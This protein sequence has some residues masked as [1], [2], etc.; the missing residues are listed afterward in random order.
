[1]IQGN[2]SA[3]EITIKRLVGRQRVF[4][5]SF[6]RERSREKATAAVDERLEVLQNSKMT[7]A[8]KSSSKEERE[9][10]AKQRKMRK[11]IKNK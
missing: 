4:S 6:S 7:T 2:V 10:R 5:R 1:M 11:T 9:D 8:S 3:A